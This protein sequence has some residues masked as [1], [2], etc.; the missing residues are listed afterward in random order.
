[1]TFVEYNAVM[2]TAQSSTSTFVRQ[3][4]RQLLRE[5]AAVPADGQPRASSTQ[6]SDPRVYLRV[7][8]RALPP[9]DPL[10]ENSPVISTSSAQHHLYE[11]FIFPTPEPLEAASQSGNMATVEGQGA[12]DALYDALYTLANPVHSYAYGDSTGWLVTDSGYEMLLNLLA[13]RADEEPGYLAKAFTRSAW[14]GN[15]RGMHEPAA[16]LVR[17]AT[18]HPAFVAE[19]LL[20]RHPTT[21]LFFTHRGYLNAIKRYGISPDVQEVPA[22]GFYAVDTDSYADCRLLLGR[23]NGLIAV[24]FTYQGPCIRGLSPLNVPIYRIPDGVGVEA[25]NSIIDAA[26]NRDLWMPTESQRAVA[27]E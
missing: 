26:S 11:S 24:E 22:R 18:R 15:N 23:I 27:V 25:I 12:Q 2:N 14:N 19:E 8:H 21:L 7:S 4:V 10:V 6:L 16:I 1:M 3:I 5:V 9:G 13:L 20:F 17:Q